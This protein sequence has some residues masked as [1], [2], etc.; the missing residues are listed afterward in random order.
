MAK[1]GNF[2]SGDFAAM[3][4]QIEFEKLNEPDDQLAMESVR[5]CF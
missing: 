4:H 2:G 3:E 1:N 5:S